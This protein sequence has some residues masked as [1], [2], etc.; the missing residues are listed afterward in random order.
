MS[1]NFLYMGS[2]VVQSLS[3]RQGP[4]AKVS[5]LHLGVIVFGHK[6]LVS[7]HSLL[8]GHPY[9]IQQIQMQTDL[10]LI[11]PFVMVGY[12]IACYP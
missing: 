6:V 9:L 12:P 7:D 5:R 2:L 4:D 8:N 3:S 11:L 10:L 1:P